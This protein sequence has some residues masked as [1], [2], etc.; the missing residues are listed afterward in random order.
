M[1]TANPAFQDLDRAHVLA[2]SHDAAAPALGQPLASLRLADGAQVDF[3]EPE[4]GR[5]LVIASGALQI[6]RA[7]V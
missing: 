2:H 7:H 5:V 1:N 6:G 4:A 3:Y